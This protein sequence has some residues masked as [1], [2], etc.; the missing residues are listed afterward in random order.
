MVLIYF[1]SYPVSYYFEGTLERLLKVYFEMFT[2]AQVV[3]IEIVTEP[4]KDSLETL[5]AQN[6]II[7]RNFQY[8][9][10]FL[11]SHIKQR[12]A[13]YTSLPCFLSNEVSALANPNRKKN[14]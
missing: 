13:F 3:N 1:L 8:R 6:L 12:V 14:T 11:V 7:L 10:K 2:R 5:S 9:P 4:L